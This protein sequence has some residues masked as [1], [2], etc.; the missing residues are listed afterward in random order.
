MTLSLD[1][2]R[3][4]GLVVEGDVARLAQVVSNLLTNAAKYTP[5]GGTID[6]DCG[7]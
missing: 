6:C 2:P 3:P 7:P 5:R 1:V 4:G